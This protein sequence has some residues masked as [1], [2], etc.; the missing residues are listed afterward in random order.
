MFA[1]IV[2]NGI[3]QFLQKYPV[4]L[5]APVI[6]ITVDLYSSDF[7]KNLN[8]YIL[9]LCTGFVCTLSLLLLSCYF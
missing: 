5:Q 3:A 4:I 1:H 2:G 6:I 8:S 9:V 7:V